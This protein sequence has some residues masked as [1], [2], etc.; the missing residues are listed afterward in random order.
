[1]QAASGEVLC[2]TAAAP[3]APAGPLHGGWPS[4]NAIMGAIAAHLR[5]SGGALSA[6]TAALSAEEQALSQVGA[7]CVVREPTPAAGGLPSLT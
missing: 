6:M 2:G 7:A 5:I 3:L 1:M 4:Q